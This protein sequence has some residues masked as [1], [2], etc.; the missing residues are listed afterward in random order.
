M[1]LISIV[2]PI[3]D[4]FSNVS[5]L[6]YFTTTK[7]I[8]HFM[9]GKYIYATASKNFSDLDQKHF[10][11][12]A[13]KVCLL[14]DCLPISPCRFGSGKSVRQ[15]WPCSILMV[16]Q[17]R[18]AC[19]TLN[20]RRF[21][22]ALFTGVYHHIDLNNLIGEQK[23]LSKILCKILIWYEIWPEIKSSTQIFQLTRV[24]FAQKVESKHP[25]FLIESIRLYWNSS[26]TCSFLRFIPILGKI[27]PNIL[28]GLL[29]FNLFYGTKRMK[30]TLGYFRKDP[31]TPRGGQLD[32]QNISLMP[33]G[34]PFQITWLHL[35]FQVYI[36]A[37]TNCLWP[38]KISDFQSILLCLTANVDFQ[39]LW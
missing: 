26:L 8:K 20:P 33:H 5:L 1:I 13:S 36:L 21:F 34:F 7:F 29:I 2:C 15:K 25:K 35:D 30:I 24:A 19:I 31:H 28:N 11:L 12:L 39:N 16:G 6:A 38:E 27:L 3:W 32:F 14:C 18:L 23:I 4:G 37:A 9:F 10:C 17:K 22:L